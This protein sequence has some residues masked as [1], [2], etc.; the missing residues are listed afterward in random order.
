MQV[1]AGSFGV[2]LVSAIMTLAACCPSMSSD[3]PTTVQPTETLSVMPSVLRDVEL[4][5]PES[6]CPAA[7][8]SWAGI[9]PGKS[10]KA[11][12]VNVL[13]EPAWWERSIDGEKV[14]VY[15]P[16]VAVSVDSYGNNIAFRDDDVVDWIDVWVLDSD[17][18]FHAVIE[19]V[20]LYGVSLDRVYLNGRG[21]V[22][23]PDHVYV[24]SQCGIAITAVHKSQGE[25]Q[26]EDQVLPSVEAAEVDSYQLDLRHPVHPWAS[27]QPR[28]DVRQIVVR[29]FL[30]QPTDFSSFEQF[31]AHNVPYLLDSQYYNWS[32]AE[33]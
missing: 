7:F 31:Y 32:F 28:P 29:K 14:F 2:F 12:V 17:G 15:P 25:T 21:D 13:G 8:A 3:V 19:F 6:T 4:G 5:P 27:A 20:Q 1:R 26:Q 33:E 22:S 9:V 23:G 11:D 16:V 18:K 30:F 24:W 10:T